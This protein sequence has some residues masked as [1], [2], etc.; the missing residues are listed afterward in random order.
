VTNHEDNGAALRATGG[1]A[2]ISSIICSRKLVVE[3]VLVI[4]RLFVVRVEGSAFSVDGSTGTRDIKMGHDV[5]SCSNVAP[6]GSLLS[7]KAAVQNAF[8]TST[9][10]LISDME[11]VPLNGKNEAR[12]C[13]SL[14]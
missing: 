10:R 13:R 2:F 7:N 8:T 3:A 6:A 9:E 1:A 5:N 4:V 14:S 11:S 12:C